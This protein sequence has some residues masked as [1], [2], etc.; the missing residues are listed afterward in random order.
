VPAGMMIAPRSLVVG[1]PARMLRT[2]SDDDILPNREG[3]LTYQALT[4][5]CLQTLQEVAAPPHAEAIWQR[6]T[7]PRVRPPTTGGQTAVMQP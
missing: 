4:I 5:R 1:A 6:L 2:P 7:V 3:M